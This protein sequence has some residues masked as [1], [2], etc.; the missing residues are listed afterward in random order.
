MPFKVP[1]AFVACFF[2]FISD[3]ELLQKV[4]QGGRYLC[5]VLDELA[6]IGG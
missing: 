5:K 1:K 2:P 3:G 6:I 4:C